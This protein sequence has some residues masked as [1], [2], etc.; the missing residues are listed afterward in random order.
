MTKKVCINVLIFTLIFCL[1]FQIVTNLL[2]GEQFLTL[3]DI[4][5]DI[6]PYIFFLSVALYVS[7]NKENKTKS[8]E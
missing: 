4:K 6:L 3:S 8:A 1:A 2:S 5:N 7:Y